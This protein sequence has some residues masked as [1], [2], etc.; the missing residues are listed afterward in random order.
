MSEHQTNVAGA[1]W[2]NEPVACYIHEI[3][4]FVETEL[5][6]LYGH[7]RSSLPFFETFRTTKNVGTY[8][9]SQGGRLTIILL[10]QSKGRKIN[11]L[12]EMIPIDGRE[13]HRFADYVFANFPAVDT[14]SFKAIQTDIQCLPFP[15]QRHNSIEDFV[16]TLPQTPNEYTSR[17]GPATRRSIHRYM[18]RIVRDFPT[19]SYTFYR[20]EE[21]DE[22]DIREIIE[23]SRLRVTARKKRFGIDEN[24][25]AHVFRL[26]RSSGLVNVITIGGRVCAGTITCRVGGNYFSLVNA[27]SSEFDQYRLGT[28]CAYLTVCECIVSGAKRFSMGPGR[29]DYKQRLLAVRQ[30]MDQLE[31]Y[32]SY[33]RAVLNC[34]H[35]VKTFADSRVR[36]VKVWLL[37]REKSLVT[38][39]VLHTLFYIRTLRSSGW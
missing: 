4:S 12:N 5:E 34:D 20:N 27:H 35:V 7:L 25:L 11:V 8:F 9:V 1:A 2:L 32:R 31:I 22:Q 23:L 17:I 13:I 33:G 3:P 29:Y 14:I 6:R 30:D 37:E 18:K 16:I 10:I 19:F 24:D 36:R 38:Q 28:L 26:V 15:S 21:I 39:F